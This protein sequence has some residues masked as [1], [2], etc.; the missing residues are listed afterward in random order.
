[1]KAVTNLGLPK[2]AEPLVLREWLCNLPFSLLGF[3]MTILNLQ[4]G[5]GEGATQFAEAS[6]PST[7]PRT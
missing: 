5:L 4:G 7:L 6:P 2:V 3:E 1:M